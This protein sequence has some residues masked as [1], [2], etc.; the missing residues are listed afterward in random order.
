MAGVRAVHATCFPWG[1]ANTVSLP[2][3][4]LQSQ[5][6]GASVRLFQIMDR[7]PELPISGGD[8]PEQMGAALKLDNVHFKYPSRP[9]TKVCPVQETLLRF[10]MLLFSVPGVALGVPSYTILYT[11]THT[12]THTVFSRLPSV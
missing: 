2:G 6:L 5:A 9:D 12:H 3:M 7:K 11:H 1:R 10:C 4:P 8:R